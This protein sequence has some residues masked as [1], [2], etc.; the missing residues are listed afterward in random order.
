[1]FPEA[2]PADKRDVQRQ[3]SDSEYA[4]LLKDHKNMICAYSCVGGD[5]NVRRTVFRSH[6]CRL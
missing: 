5:K 3:D 4:K 2:G 1:M 6:I